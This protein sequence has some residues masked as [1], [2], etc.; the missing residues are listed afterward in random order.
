MATYVF[1]VDRVV[2]LNCRS[3]GDH[4]DSDWLSLYLKVNDSARSVGPFNIGP[5]IHHGDVLTGPWWFGPADIS[6]SDNVSFTYTITNLSHLS[7][8]NEQRG[9]AVK[10]ESAVL[11]GIVAAVGGPI[12]AVV[13][14]VLAGLGE[15]FGWI[16][17]HTNPN[18]NGEVLHDTFNYAPGE[19]VRQGT[20]HSVTNSYTAISP[21][22]CGNS[23][24]TD[25]TYSVIDPHSLKQFLAMHHLH[26]NQGL[27]KALPAGM[28]VRTFESMHL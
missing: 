1:S 4:N 10:V 8:I 18:C 22:E 5:N 21:S 27:R 26:G 20:P 23:P 19:L 28:S 13:G 24:Q 3:K 15:V 11:G 7:D 2:V 12:G 9:E 14:T 25:L 16:I 17:E 6:D